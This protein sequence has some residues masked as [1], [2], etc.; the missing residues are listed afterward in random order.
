[1]SPTVM[2]VGKADPWFGSLAD[3]HDHGGEPDYPPEAYE[4]AEAIKAAEPEL[5]PIMMILF[6]LRTN[7]ATRF[8]AMPVPRHQHSQ[9]CGRA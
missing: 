6:D 7:V 1:M 9:T 3:L 8:V 2:S 5:G 4:A